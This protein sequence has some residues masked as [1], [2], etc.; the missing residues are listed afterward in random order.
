[1]ELITAR[2]KPRRNLDMRRN[3]RQRA[4]EL[5]QEAYKRYSESIQEALDDGQLRPEEVDSWTP[6]GY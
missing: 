3:I 4:W 1:M 5:A 2:K 6:R